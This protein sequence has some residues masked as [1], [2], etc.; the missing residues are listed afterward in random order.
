MTK[1]PLQQAVLAAGSLAA[2]LSGRGARRKPHEVTLD[3][4]TA[5]CAQ[6]ISNA[7][8]TVKEP[9]DMQLVRDVVQALAAF[10]KIRVLHTEVLRVFRDLPAA[11][12]KEMPLEMVVEAI[13]SYAQFQI[14]DLEF[15]RFLADVIVSRNLS[16]LKDFQL[17]NLA[18]AAATLELEED[19]LYS[20]FQAAFKQANVKL[21]EQSAGY[22]RLRGSIW[23]LKNVLMRGTKTL[24]TSWEQ[25]RT[26]QLSFSWEYFSQMF[27]RKSSSSH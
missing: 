26:E 21:G 6:E 12:W 7:L 15:N 16:N 20:C 14:E 2:S 19:N 13:T 11:V 27:D 24:T 17:A 25:F 22:P 8:V 23:N 5:E 10:A 18:F 3:P 9:T 4:K 1:S